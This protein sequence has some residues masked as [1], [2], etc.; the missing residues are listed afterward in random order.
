MYLDSIP[1]RMLAIRRVGES[2]DA[3]ASLEQPLGDVAAGVAEGA[4]YYVQFAIISHRGPLLLPN[5]PL[6][7]GATMARLQHRP[8]AVGRSNRMSGSLTPTVASPENTNH[9]P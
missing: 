5:A 4:R 7:G 6:S 2:S 8:L 3:V 9:T 1:E